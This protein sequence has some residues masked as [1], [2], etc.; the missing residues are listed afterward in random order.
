MYNIYARLNIDNANYTLSV[1]KPSTRAHIDCLIHNTC[2]YIYISIYIWYTV[3][4]L[5]CE[6]AEELN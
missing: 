3:V 6:T 1:D 4:Q 2:T 5:P